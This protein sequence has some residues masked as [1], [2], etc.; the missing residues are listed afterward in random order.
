MTVKEV[1]SAKPPGTVQLDLG[2]RVIVPPGAANTAGVLRIS[3]GLLYLWAF[4]SQGFG[5]VYANSVTNAAGQA[6]SYGWHFSYDASLGWIMSGFTH[7]PTAPFIA[8]THGPLAFISQN[9][10]A[11]VDDFGWMFALGGLGI[12]LTLG[13]AMRIA[14]WG[15]FALNIMLWFSLFPPSGNPVIDGEHMA[16]AFGIL[17]LMFL[18]A[19]NRF[20][21]GRWWEAHTPPLIH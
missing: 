11:G 4:I 9:L 3:L 17:L 5:V 12:A 2:G 20:G 15:G 16:F 7:S 8:S 13:I 14:G 18:H 1:S 10:P 21:L 6:T 19:G